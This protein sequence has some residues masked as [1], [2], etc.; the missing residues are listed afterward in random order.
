MT[1]FRR[2]IF[3]EFCHNVARGDW[4]GVLSYPHSVT[5]EPCHR[6]NFFMKTAAE[7]SLMK[8]TLSIYFHG[9]IKRNPNKE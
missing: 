7:L 8:G 1:C 5:P 2:S 6:I 4:Y 3:H 9:M